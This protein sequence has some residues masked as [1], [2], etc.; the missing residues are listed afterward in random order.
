ME[1]TPL[2]GV[3][4]LGKALIWIKSIDKAQFAGTTPLCD[5]CDEINVAEDDNVQLLKLGI[6]ITGA[7]QSQ[8]TSNDLIGLK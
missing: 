4:L 1:K 3:H 8:C 5:Q 2:N 6:Q 7:R